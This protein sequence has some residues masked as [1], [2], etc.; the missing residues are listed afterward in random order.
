LA[1]VPGFAQQTACLPLQQG[2]TLVAT[3]ASGDT[4]AR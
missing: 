2:M 3:D 1:A 4:H